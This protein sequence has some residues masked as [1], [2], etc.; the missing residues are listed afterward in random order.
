[1]VMIMKRPVSNLNLS[2]Y[3]ILETI[4]DNITGKNSSLLPSPPQMMNP[5][6]D[7]HHF[8][9][10]EIGERGGLLVKEILGN[11]ICKQAVKLTL[12]NRAG[13]TQ[14]K[15]TCTI[16]PF[17]K[18]QRLDDEGRCFSKFVIVW[19]LLRREAFWLSS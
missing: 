14:D 6:A 16:Q 10:F 17:H 19:K 13:I 8:F 11:E 3:V 12:V 7:A 15:H 4:L 5:R 2:R 18:I 9:I 1:M